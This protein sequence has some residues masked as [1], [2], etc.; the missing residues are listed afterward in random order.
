MNEDLKEYEEKKWDKRLLFEEKLLNLKNLLYEDRHPSEIDQDELVEI[1]KTIRKFINKEDPDR[2]YFVKYKR[3]ILD[4][5]KPSFVW[6]LIFVLCSLI[7]LYQVLKFIV[8]LIII[9]VKYYG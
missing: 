3:F 9:L 7:G 2:G 5:R 6:F 4:I 1:N 8:L